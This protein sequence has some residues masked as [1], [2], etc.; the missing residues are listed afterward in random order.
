[1]ANVQ[2]FSY[3][4][5]LMLF[6]LGALVELETHK[7]LQ[8]NWT[9]EFVQPRGM[10][11][12]DQLVAAGFVPTK[13]E[14]RGCLI[15]ITRRLSLATDTANIENIAALIAQWDQ[16]VQSFDQAATTPEDGGL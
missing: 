1:M 16:T 10:A 3:Q 14:A 9:S 12:F 8:G 2:E 6:V 11:Q 4:S 15:A 5:K 7:Y 13:E